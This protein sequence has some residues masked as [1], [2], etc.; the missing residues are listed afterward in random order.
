MFRAP[1]N[2][3]IVPGLPFYHVGYTGKYTGRDTVLSRYIDA[4][5]ADGHD[6]CVAE[7]GELAWEKNTTVTE[8]PEEASIRQLVRPLLHTSCAHPI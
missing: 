7:T 5:A 3:L 8:T 1:L 2:K 6:V 4:M